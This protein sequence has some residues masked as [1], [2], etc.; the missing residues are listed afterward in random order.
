MPMGSPAIDRI[1][2]GG[3]V[4]SGTGVEPADVLIAGET[5]AAIA[6]PGAIPLPD[7]VERIDAAG[8]WVLPGMVD[9][10]VHLREPGYVHKEDISTCTAAA[11]AGGVTTVFGMPNLNPVT[12][13][14]QVLE[15]LFDLYDAKSI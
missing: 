14:L 3:T 10:H 2:A 4:V 11:A 7:S 9:V 8:K 12:K 6:A 5:I 1:V 13:N 15:E